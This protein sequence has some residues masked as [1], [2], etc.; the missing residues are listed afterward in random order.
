[1]LLHHLFRS[2]QTECPRCL[3]KGHVDS[4]DIRRL[5]ME[6]RWA[7]GAC[8][9]CNGTGKVSARMVANL[10]AD[11]AYLTS[12]LPPEE[13]KKL[14]HADESALARAAHT[15]AQYADFIK[16]IEYLHQVGR[17]SAE[18]ILE[19]YLL[20]ESQPAVSPE[21]KQMLRELIEKVI[22]RMTDAVK[23]S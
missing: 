7:P 5:K 8:A 9:Y 17:M 1:M 20:P 14:I 16:G 15:D 3:G 23:W 18:Q 13:R 19:F 4:A 12:N 6:L 2:S 11:F 10:P 22:R 21:E